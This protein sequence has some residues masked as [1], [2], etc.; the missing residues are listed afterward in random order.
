MKPRL[1][2]KKWEIAY[3]CPGYEK[4]FFE[5]FDT[6][7][8]AALRAA[9][10]SLDRK[11]GR[12]VPPVEK[13]DPDH[14][15]AAFRKQVTVARLMDE[16]INV[17]GKTQWSGN[18][19]SCYRARTA[20]YI[21]PHIGD[22]KLVDITSHFLTKY[23]SSLLGTETI[24]KKG[25]QPKK[26]SSCVVQEVHKIL[27]SAFNQAIR[28]EWMNGSNPADHATAPS[29]KH[30]HRE[31]MTESELQCALTNAD[32][33]ILNLCIHLALGCSMRIGEIL[34]L[35]WDDIH[36]EPDLIEQGD[37]FLHIGKQ[38]QRLKKSDIQNMQLVD[39]DSIQYIFPDIVPNAKTSLVLSKPKTESSTRDN[40]IPRTIAQML[41]A[42]RVRQNELKNQ[43]QH[44]Y[45]DYNLVIAQN[46]GRPYERRMIHNSLRELE[47]SQGLKTVV[48]HS[49][50]H[51]STSLKLKIGGGDIKSVQGDTGHAQASMVTD[52]Y[53]HIATEDRKRLAIGIDPFFSNLK[54]HKAGEIQES[55]NTNKILSLIRD[56]PEKAEKLLKMIELLG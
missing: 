10:I 39:S 56:N 14:D 4:T 19:A 27:R 5:S 6:E 40:Y 55:D 47:E 54:E 3:R 50:R 31:V 49:F 43:L 53:S 38:L 35:T 44:E 22:V 2:G 51:S 36:V 18:T 23:Y 52:V 12:L 25:Q 28:W 34:G 21:I 41:V 48:F 16:Y 17:Y 24:P 30:K 29:Y 45:Y 13:M 20:R 8:E 46:N 15:L 7:E 37:A 33:P 42:H 11:L 26:V 32:D 1:H 9:Q